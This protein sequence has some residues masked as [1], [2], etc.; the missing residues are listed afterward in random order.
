MEELNL[1]IPELRNDM[2]QMLQRWI[3][4]PSLKDTPA[5][6][7]PFGAE[8]NRMLLTALADAEALGFATR[9]IDGYAGDIR[10]GPLGENPLAV[11]AH[12]DVVP[13]G[14]GWQTNPFEAVITDDRIY[15]R[16]TSDDKGPAVAALFAMLAIRQAGIPLSREVRLILGCDEETGMEDM[17]YYREHY[18]IPKTGFTP[19]ASFPVIN[20]EKGLMQLELR[21]PAA[22]E[23]LQVESIS[24]GERFNV[25]PGLAK[26]MV[27]GTQALC[28]KVNRLAG[29]MHL[30]VSADMAGEGLVCLTSTGITGHAAYPEAAR[31]A[32]DQLLLM[33][34]ALGVCGPLKVMADC[35][36]MTSD[37]HGLNIHCRDEISGALTCNLGIMRYDASGMYAT[38]DIRFPL[39][40]NADRILKTLTAALGDTI[41]V[42]VAARKEPHH[43]APTSELVT[44]LLDAYHDE[45]GRERECVSTGGGTYARCLEEGV[46]FGASFPEDEDLAHQAG[47]YISIDNM[48]QDVRIFANAI[49]RLAGKPN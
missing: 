11:L 6:G 28:E 2:I 25:V 29:D 5:E 40:A 18:D 9:N 15:G 42:T 32:I 23:G 27:R 4:I 22:T 46:A 36:S 38:F 30:S 13:A 24:V 34:R 3:A 35:V 14:D 47:E 21:S 44:A 20:T 37:G 10:M 26:A 48:L 49:V 39:L 7:A 31:N 41:S 1:I 12:L 8:V 16:G 17:A 43:V 33:L 45:T 19:D